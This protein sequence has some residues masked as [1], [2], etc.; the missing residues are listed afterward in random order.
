MSTD[1]VDV[2]VP[3]SMY[4]IPAPSSEP[5]L[6][7]TYFVPPAVQGVLMHGPDPITLQ[8]LVVKQIEYYFRCET[9]W[10]FLEFFLFSKCI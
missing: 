6:G 10:L 4:Y 5:I 7:A 3:G 8:G 2:D 9:L 1:V